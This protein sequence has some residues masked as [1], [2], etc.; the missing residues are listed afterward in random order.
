M[1]LR[2]AS[3][4]RGC[5]AT[6]SIPGPIKFMVALDPKGRALMTR[7]MELIR[8]IIAEIQSRKDAQP[9]SLEIPDVDEAIVSRH[10]EMLHSANLIEGHKSDSI[11]SPFPYFEVTDLSMS[12]HDFA[13]ALA[14]ESIWAQI[15]ESFSPNQ[16]KTLPL[17]VV[18]DVG[19]GLL[20]KWALKQAG[21]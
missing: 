16:L 6:D 19:V 14:N 5:A 10:L 17:T 20:A 15:K 9:R 7:D 4:F 13:A 11:D 21:L 1:K 3:E 18:K 8:K 12:G 2:R